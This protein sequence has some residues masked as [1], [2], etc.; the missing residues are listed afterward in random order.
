MD[1]NVIEKQ[2]TNIS[3]I[4]GK[5]F[6]DKVIPLIRKTQKTIDIIVY[7]WRWHPDQIGSKIQRF[8]NELV[9]CRRKNNRIRVITDSPHLLTILK[10][11]N[12]EVKKNIS[13]RKLHTKLMIIDSKTVILGSHNYTMNAFTINY[14][15]S[16]IVE[17]EKAVARLKLYFE[18]LW[19]L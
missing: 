18:N 13:K 11:V 15:V 8:N 2:T 5:E 19:G 4:I 6:A 14:E 17:D 3:V 9:M 10:N 16:V 7:D 1:N 12:F